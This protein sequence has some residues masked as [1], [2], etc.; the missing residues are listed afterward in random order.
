[1]ELFTLP[2]EKQNSTLSEDTSSDLDNVTKREATSSDSQTD[3]GVS[4]GVMIMTSFLLAE[5]LITSLQEDL[6]FYEQAKEF[7]QERNMDKFP[8]LR[9]V[10]KQAREFKR[11]S[12][13]RRKQ[14][15]EKCHERRS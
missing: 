2:R 15:A 13:D 1:M 5:A 6:G 8:Y 11:L 10:L 3:T 4:S 9:I 14:L 12:L 7:V